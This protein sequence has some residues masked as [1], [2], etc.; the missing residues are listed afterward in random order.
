MIK[1]FKFVLLLSC[2]MHSIQVNLL[3]SN[4][5]IKSEPS[6]DKKAKKRRLRKA[7][8]SRDNGFKGRLIKKRMDDFLKT[9]PPEHH[10]KAQKVITYL[11]TSHRVARSHM[12][13]KN[14]SAALEIFNKRLRLKVPDFFENAPPILKYFK[15]ATKVAI[16]KIHL[17]EKN[18]ERALQALES[19]YE[20]ALKLKDF[21]KPIMIGLRHQLMRAYRMVGMAN[22][23][24]MMLESTLREAEAEVEFE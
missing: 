20:E 14:N 9:V 12:K 3:A 4:P 18:G 17:S 7:K 11:H 15:L 19:S 5:I 2:V 21:P 23:A 22:K 13:N 16:G 24:D 8:R 10:E 1:Y 6:S